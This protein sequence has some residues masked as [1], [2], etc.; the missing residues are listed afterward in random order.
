[1]QIAA[2]FFAFVFGTFVIVKGSDFLITASI[3]LQKLTGL[4][5]IVIGATF[6]SVATTL[7]EVFVST[8]AIV[9]G[10]Y[11]IAV[12]N[13]VGSMIF[14][15]GVIVPIYLLA[16]SQ[17]I[18]RGGILWKA[19][20]LFW[21]VFTLILFSANGQIGLSEGVCLLLLFVIFI[22]LN[23]NKR[24]KDKTAAV[25]EENKEENK[26]KL[27]SVIWQIAGLFV[28]GQIMLVGGAYL[29]VNNGEKIANMFNIPEGIIAIT[30]IAIGTGLPE[31]FTAI[32][33]IKKHHSGLA[34]GNI[35]GSCVFNCTLLLGSC[36]V[37]SYFC[38]VPLP[39]SQTTQFLSLPFMLAASLAAFLPIIIFQKTN[40]FLGGLLIL[41]YTGYLFLLCS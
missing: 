14:N 35:L 1:V 4:S 31:L 39:I 29:L 20:Y 27:P 37:I 6:I 10:D 7:P 9:G 17:G 40:R 2:V 5:E 8:F 11:E 25:I 41:M 13:A 22:V 19:V 24:S 15:V 34:V 36:S 21:T 28:F 3:K 33:G 38:G 12:G 26:V 32:C 16:I 18:R 23:I 30:F